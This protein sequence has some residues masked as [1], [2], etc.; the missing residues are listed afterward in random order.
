MKG[1]KGYIHYILGVILIIAG[2]FII[3]KY[4][5]ASF[6]SFFGSDVEFTYTNQHGKEPLMIGMKQF[7]AY[8]PEFTCKDDG[9]KYIRYPY[10]SSKC[11][12]SRIVY[13][14]QEHMITC[15]APIWLDD[16]LKVAFWPRTSGKDTKVSF[17]NGIP[18]YNKE[19]DWV[20]EYKFGLMNSNVL[21]SAVVESKDQIL[22]GDNRDVLI[23]IDNT[24][25]EFD[26]DHSGVWVRSNHE[27][28]ERAEEWDDVRMPLM[29]GAN[30]YLIE[31]DGTELGT[32][33]TE[34]QPYVVIDA[35][36]KVIIRQKN[37]TVIEHEVVLDDPEIVEK[38]SWL[39]RF[40]GWIKGWFA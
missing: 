27:L 29:E 18:F 15:S 25:A 32:V 21:S 30:K 40:W 38:K 7:Q 17:E 28:L 9:R 16:N 14:G 20:A 4:T 19:T 5:D 3:G 6:L 31:L 36:K 11:W 1:K 35:D 8:P 12:Q 2:I 23:E 33:K 34:I 26:E 22:I 24:L 37:P 39:A 13:D 10:P